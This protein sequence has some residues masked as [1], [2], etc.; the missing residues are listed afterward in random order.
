VTSSDA[1]PTRQPGWRREPALPKSLD[2]LEGPLAGEVGLSLDTFWSGP[3]PTSARWD[4]GNA[5][6]RRSLYEIVLQ[7]GS[8]AD[9]RAL[10]NGAELVRLWDALYLPTWV[11][12]AW[13]PLIDSARPAA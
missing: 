3:D 6:A 8:L 10:I 7:R 4:L 9:V 13:A 5:A 1:S 2:E 12:S 11:R